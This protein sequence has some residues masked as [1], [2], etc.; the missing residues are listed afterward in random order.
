MYMPTKNNTPAGLHAIIQMSS[1]LA[2]FRGALVQN[3]DGG[4]LRF[5]NQKKIK[6]RVT[7]KLFKFYDLQITILKIDSVNCKHIGRDDTHTSVTRSSVIAK[8]LLDAS[9]QLKS[10]QL[11]RNSTET[12]CTTSPEQIEVMKFE[13]YS[14]CNKHVHST[15]TRSSRFHCLTGVINKP[16]TVELCISPVY[17][18]LAGAKF[19]KSTM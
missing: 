6:L 15:M 10:C 4:P 7:S 1:G 12:T 14:G 3:F 19:S 16:T 5:Q 2:R 11:P 18:R 8:G 9:C 13:G 17:R